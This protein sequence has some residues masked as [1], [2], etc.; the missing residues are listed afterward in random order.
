MTK[1]RG[2]GRGGGVLCKKVLLSPMEC[3]EDESGDSEM[4]K[5]DNNEVD[6]DV[7]YEQ[8]HN[9]KTH[10]KINIVKQA[11]TKTITGCN[12]SRQL[13]E[14]ENKIKSLKEVFILLLYSKILA[15]DKP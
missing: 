9:E 8:S 1:E 12:C 13:M 6:F 7:V 11:N 4:A 15:N 3:L 2:G 10:E 14:H 5:V